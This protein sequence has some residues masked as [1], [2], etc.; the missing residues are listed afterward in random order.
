MSLGEFDIV[1]NSELIVDVPKFF[2]N[3]EVSSLIGM[4][5]YAML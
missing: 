2:V 5:F 4:F 3:F 1:L